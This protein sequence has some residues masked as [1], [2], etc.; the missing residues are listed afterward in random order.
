M[1]VRPVGAELFHVDGQTDT[2]KPVVVIR[3]SAYAHR[4]TTIYTAVNAVIQTI[5]HA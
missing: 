1:A 3:N 2:T 5:G 4:N